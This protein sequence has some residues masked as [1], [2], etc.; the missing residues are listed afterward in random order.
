MPQLWIINGKGSANR[1]IGVRDSV[2]HNAAV[3]S[4]TDADIGPS[5]ESLAVP[6]LPEP[7]ALL[8]RPVQRY[9]TKKSE[10]PA[11]PGAIVPDFAGSDR[12]SQKC[13]GLATSWK[14]R[15]CSI[16]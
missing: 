8:V 10:C 12:M 7:L 14:Y 16:I 15:V 9:A 13:E 4:L 11:L 3:R 1:M 5:D 2:H 6:H